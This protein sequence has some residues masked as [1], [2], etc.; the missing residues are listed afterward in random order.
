MSVFASVLGLVLL[1]GAGVTM[2]LTGLPVFIVLIMATLLGLAVGLLSGSVDGALIAALPG[3]LTNVLDNDLLQ[4]LPLFVLMGVLL[5]KLPLAGNLFSLA[6]RAAPKGTAGPLFA[7]LGLG[8]LLGPMN[9]SVGASVLALNRA[10]APR[11]EKAGLSPALTQGLIAAAATLGVVV[12]PSLVLILLGDAMLQAHTI[13]LNITGRS[14][15]IINTQDLLRGALV[16]AGLALG[17]MAVAAFILARKVRLTTM[18]PLPLTRRAMMGA[19]I[20][21]VALVSLL[22]AVALGKLYAVEAAATGALALFIVALLSGFLDRPRLLATLNETLATTGALFALLVAATG[23]TLM[24]RIFGTDRLVSDFLTSLPGGPTVTLAIVLAIIALSAL[25]LDAFEII[26]VIIPIVA[27]P[28]LVTVN[29]PVWASV[30]ILLALQASFLLPPFGYA[31]MMTRAV[32]RV[33]LSLKALLRP[34]SYFLA[35]ELVVLLLLLASPN[36]VHVLDPPGARDRG[37]KLLT[38]DELKKNLDGLAV[39]EAP[40]VDLKF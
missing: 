1:A 10:I 19:L 26:F 21:L 24:L 15:R 37:T 40:P 16:P 39:P 11:L 13:A 12:P 9:G 8:A 17:A 7:G 25:V 29:D 36:L 5:E 6:M 30:A 18:P 23:F 31:L 28:L 22:G 14:E 34:V 32:S 27:P 3:R 38:P 35:A 4:A 33:P 2:I 20:A